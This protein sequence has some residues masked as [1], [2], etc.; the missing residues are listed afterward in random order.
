LV[1]KGELTHIQRVWILTQVAGLL[2]K[3]DRDNALTTINDAIAEA[4][5]ID[6]SDPDRP[7]GLFAIANALQGLD[8]V[9]AWEIAFDAVKAGNAAESFTGEDAVLILGLRSSTQIFNRR[10]PNPDF[11]VKGIFGKLAAVDANRTIE[12]ARAFQGEGPRAIATI[13]IAKAL[14]SSETRP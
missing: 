13:A 3:T 7:R 14:L 8:A 5:R 2:A 6:N 9:R 10:D 1:R 12:L 11:D 4:G